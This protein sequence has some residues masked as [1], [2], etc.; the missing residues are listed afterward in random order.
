MSDIKDYTPPAD[1][2]L[3]EP[4]Y[5][6]TWRCPI[7]TLYMSTK[8]IYSQSTFRIRKIRHTGRVVGYK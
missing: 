5:A 1:S 2:T 8:Q 4:I 6:I 7:A 3:S